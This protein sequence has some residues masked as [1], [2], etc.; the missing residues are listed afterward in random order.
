MI[1]APLENLRARIQSKSA[2]VGIFGAGYAGLPLACAFADAGYRTTAGDN[3]QSKIEQLRKGLSYVEDPSVKSML[4]KLISSG[5]LQATEDLVALASASDIAMITVPTPLDD[6]MLPDLSFVTDIAGTI[7]EELKPGKMV[8]LES[9]VFPGTTTELVRPILEKSGLRAGRDF[10]LAHSPERIDYGNPTPLPDIPKVVGG[11]TRRCTDLAVELYSKILRGK[12]VQVSDSRTAE[13][14]KML[15]N[16]Y[17]YVNIAF[18]NEMAMACEKLGVDAFEVIEAAAT[19]PFGYEKF[20]PGPGVGGHCIPKDPHYLAFKA[21]QVGI[22]LGM[23]E[24]ATSINAKMPNHILQML[25]DSLTRRGRKLQGLTAV[26]LGLAFKAD[27]SDTR[28][29]PSITLAEQLVEFGAEVRAYDPLARNIL[30]RKGSLASSANLQ[31]AINGADLI[32]L[33][34]PHTAFR[35]IDL[36]EMAELAH[37]N[38]TIFD[39]RGFWSRREC[40]AAGFTYLCVGRPT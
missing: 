39:T 35:K 23:I 16:T 32:F 9:S 6:Q 17:R 14:T 8:I 10:A 1:N 28:R 19:K 38:P 26:L 33:M 29:S 12:V 31:S 18:V 40:E 13:T 36:K 15:E 37:S 4:P 24:L 25:V 34:T 22:P 3:D 20:L 11:V 30:T 21:R 5:M 7:A 2:N 27:V